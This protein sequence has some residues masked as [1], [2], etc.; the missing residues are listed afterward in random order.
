[1]DR[2]RSNQGELLEGQFHHLHL[3]DPHQNTEE[4]LFRLD[5]VQLNLLLNFV[6]VVAVD[7]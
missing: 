1:M 3:L 4:L 2:V 7:M 6:Q 5:Q